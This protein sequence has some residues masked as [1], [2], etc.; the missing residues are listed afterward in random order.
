MASRKAL[1]FKDLKIGDEFIFAAELRF[2][3]LAKGPWTKLS[4]RSYI[5]TDKRGAIHKVGTGTADVYTK[6]S[7]PPN[8]A[9]MRCGLCKGSGA[10]RHAEPA[11][12]YEP[13]QSDT[14]PCLRC[15]GSGKQPKGKTW[16]S[17][18]G[19]SPDLR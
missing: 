2:D 9:G 15:K 5:R 14:Y 7:P 3:S 6:S 11:G 13:H 19:D 16:H 12:R 17:P 8:D 18:Y 4:A 10:P 1:K